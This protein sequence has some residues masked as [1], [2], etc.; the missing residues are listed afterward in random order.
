MK[1]GDMLAGKG[2]NKICIDYKGGSY[3]VV[4]IHSNNTIDV[5]VLNH[6][7]EGAIGKTYKFINADCYTVRGVKFG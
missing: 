3:K 5:L 7:Y 2:K 6:P 4:A 1:V